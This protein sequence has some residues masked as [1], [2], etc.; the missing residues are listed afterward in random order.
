MLAEISDSQSRIPLLCQDLGSR[1][2]GNSLGLTDQPLQ[3]SDEGS[4]TVGS[5]PPYFIEL[6]DCT[7]FSRRLLGHGF[8]L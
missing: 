5:L 1:V 8:V 7:G 2:H 6:D 3:I 4:Y